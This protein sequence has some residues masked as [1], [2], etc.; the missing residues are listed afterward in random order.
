MNTIQMKPDDIIIIVS[1]NEQLTIKTGSDGGIEVTG[2]IDNTEQM[3]QRIWHTGF[4]H[5]KSFRQFSAPI[6]W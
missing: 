5:G 4:G 6:S 1:G 3:N 2:K